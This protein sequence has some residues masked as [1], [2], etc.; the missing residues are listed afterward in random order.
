MLQHS[1]IQSNKIVK[2]LSA[3]T[4]HWLK[5]HIDFFFNFQILNTFSHSN[6][7]FVSVLIFYIYSTVYLSTMTNKVILPVFL[8]KITHY[9]KHKMTISLLHSMGCNYSKDAPH[10][11]F[12]YLQLFLSQKCGAKLSQKFDFFLFFKGFFWRT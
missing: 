1:Y 7:F 10:F 3:Y 2:N 5:N 8:K 12:L 11:C 9:C 6:D 4:N